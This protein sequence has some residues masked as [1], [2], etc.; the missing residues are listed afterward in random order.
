MDMSNSKF[1]LV[2]LFMVIFC[3]ISEASSYYVID[4]E[5]QQLSRDFAKNFLFKNNFKININK[6]KKDLMKA[7]FVDIKKELPLIEQI[8]N[9]NF[10]VFNHYPDL[11]LY[12]V[13]Y[14]NV[15]PEEF[16]TITINEEGKFIH[17]RKKTKYDGRD[18]KYRDIIIDAYKNYFGKP[19]M[20]EKIG[21]FYFYTWEKTVG[22]DYLQ[23][24]L[25]TEDVAF[26]APP[27]I[28]EIEVVEGDGEDWS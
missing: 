17:Y 27:I 18:G 20:E 25:F 21:H 15:A 8:E 10:P 26:S 6:I 14:G 12:R 4:R 1:W 22:D 9:I 23:V 24:R 7:K 28:E 13:A 3:S 19:S 11:H 16:I 5:E 2:I